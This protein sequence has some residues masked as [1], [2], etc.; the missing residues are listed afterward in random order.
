MVHIYIYIYTYLYIYIY[1][2]IIY[3]IKITP[4]YMS[5]IEN[6]IYQV[7]FIM[8]KIKYIILIKPS[9]KKRLKIRNI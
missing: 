9:T 6:L 1:I 2:Y 3:D 4:I 7:L 8:F 5:F